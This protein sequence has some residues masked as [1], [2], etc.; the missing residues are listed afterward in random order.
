[1]VSTSVAIKI[2]DKPQQRAKKQTTIPD[3]GGFLTAGSVLWLRKAQQFFFAESL[4]VDH[5]LTGNLEDEQLTMKVANDLHPE[6]E[7]L[8]KGKQDQT[9]LARARAS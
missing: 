5:D 8:T 6:M 3:A 2:I 7:T 4:H 9:K 1:M